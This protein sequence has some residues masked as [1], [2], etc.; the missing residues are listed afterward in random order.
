MS[1]QRLSPSLIGGTSHE[2][3]FMVPERDA[4]RL[5]ALARAALVADEHA[6]PR[7][8]LYPVTTLYLDTPDRAVF[9]GI[10]PHA[11]RK[12]RIRRYGSSAVLHLERKM[13]RRSRVRKIR[14]TVAE[15]R[16]DAAK[17][18]PSY[19]FARRVRLNSLEPAA[20]LT[21]SR[22][23]FFGASGGHIFRLTLDQDLR[24]A[25]PA[26]GWRVI[27]PEASL[28]FAPDHRILEVKHSGA[29]PALVRDWIGE[30]R[31]EPQAFS[32]YRTGL[33]AYA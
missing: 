5:L 24:I 26:D 16:L 9:G 18:D 2:T 30:L 33:R 8:G 19:W 20:V 17:G 7:T 12:Y 4:V 3:K 1:S 31:L 28:T 6:D 29:L 23:A 32:K 10:E 15:F 27:M 21:Y 25:A 22:A 11:S 14:W 13:K